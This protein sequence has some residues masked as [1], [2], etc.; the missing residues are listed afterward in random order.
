MLKRATHLNLIDLGR[1]CLLVVDS[2]GSVKMGTFGPPVRW[3]DPCPVSEVMLQL[4]ASAY[5]RRTRWS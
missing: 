3:V 5:P 1:G 2:M 4:T